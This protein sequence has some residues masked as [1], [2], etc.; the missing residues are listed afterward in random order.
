MMSHR[1]LVTGR[2]ALAFAAFAAS[3]AVMAAAP[4]WQPDKNVEL[5]VGAG[6]G[7]G[8]DNIARTIQ[9]ILQKKNYV[10][11]PVTVVNKPGGGG[12][13]SLAY[14]QQHAG[15]G[16]VIGI[17]S[18]TML[19]N[20]IAG[21]TQVGPADL[22]PLAILIN[23]YISFNVQ[24][25]SPLRSGKELVAKMK[26]NPAE[27]VVGISSALGNI[28][29]IAFAV[30]AREAGIDPKKAKVVVFK[31]S[32]ASMTALMGGHVHLV[33][34]PVSIA[35]RHAGSGKIRA[36]AVTAPQRR[37]GELAEVPT[38]KELGVDAVVDNWRGV[39]GPKG[40]PA[41]E[42]AYWDSVFGRL[43]KADDWQK[44]VEQNYWDNAALTS[45]DAAK[46][47]DGQYGELKKAL[48]ELELV[49]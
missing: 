24:A 3:C 5:V 15:R 29:H 17:S 35:G 14:I 1:I 8:N 40:M 26:A 19:T 13:I 32:G 41:Q 9:S 4:A 10:S 42:V 30:V 12:A 49:K 37:G 11:A 38:W 39:I 23:E 48:V 43:F 47:L 6:A 18:N 44:Q 7:G 46:Y 20:H 36:L 27:V 34:G 45:R 16:H 28:N 2:A 21:K 31:S 25:D 33:V 22:T